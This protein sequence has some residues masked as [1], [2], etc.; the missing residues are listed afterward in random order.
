MSGKIIATIYFYVLSAAAILLMVIGVFNA[1]N[2][3][4]NSTMYD[5]YPLRYSQGS[6]EFYPEKYGGSIPARI[7]LEPNATPSAE[8]SARQKSICIEM[9]EK[10]R[11]QHR[12]DD[13]KNAITFTLVGVLLFVIHFPQAKKFS[14]S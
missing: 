7:G 9:E 6:C 8:E 10:E 11:V 4:V 3:G 13:L 14:K 12:I 2:F 1:V 5:K